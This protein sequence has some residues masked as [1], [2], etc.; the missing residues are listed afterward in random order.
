[1]I[2]REVM[3]S[4]LITVAPGDTLSHA[5]NLLRQHQ[6]HHLPVVR[7][8]KAAETGKAG[9][10]TADTRFLLEGLLSSYDIDLAVALEKQNSSGNAAQ[11]PWQEQRVVEV[12]QRA[13]MSVT[14]N[15]S[16][17]AAAQ[18]MVE[19][20]LNYLP[21]VEYASAEPSSQDTQQDVQPVLLGLL[22]RS[23]LLMALV[24]ATGGFEPGMQLMLPLPPGDITPLAK[25]LMLAA[26]LHIQVPSVVAVPL[27]EGVPRVAAVH[28]STIHPAPLL[29]RLQEAG[30][31]YRF[32]DFQLEG[33]TDATRR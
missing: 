17:A 12:M 21:V 23:D 29:K 2:V 24:R 8:V 30:I 15:T 13:P 14:P 22:T 25:M 20:G 31:Q 33:D 9:Y 11:R 26:E 27:Q 19:R 28:I 4:R 18:I 1:M 6:F 32:A 3:T 7:T 16:V 5:A 10:A